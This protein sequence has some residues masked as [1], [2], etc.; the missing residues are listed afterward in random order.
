M[1][2]SARTFEQTNSKAP[3]PIFV[4]TSTGSPRTAFS[5]ESPIRQPELESLD[6]MPFQDVPPV[7]ID[8]IAEIESRRL[9]QTG[10]LSGRTVSC[11]KGKMGMALRTLNK[12]I[13][14]NGIKEEFMSRG[15]RLP[16]GEVRRNLRAKWHRI[17]FKQGVARLVGIVLRMRKKCY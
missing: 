10:T 8:N 12:I 7:S 2:I 4:P 11:P 14:E 15:Y 9:R 13:Q 16:P 6:A 5:K 1:S 3:S 17:R